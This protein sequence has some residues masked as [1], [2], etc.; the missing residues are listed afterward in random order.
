VYNKRVIGRVI[1]IILLY[2]YVSTVILLI[3]AD[4]V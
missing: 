2:R 3:C 1:R 4:A